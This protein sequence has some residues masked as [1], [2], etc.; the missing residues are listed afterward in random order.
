M[1]PCSPA[2]IFAF[3]VTYINA[4]PETY[5]KFASHFNR[6]S[7][8]PSFLAIKRFSTPPQ[9]SDLPG[10]GFGSDDVKGIKNCQTSRRIRVAEAQETPRYENPMAVQ[11]AA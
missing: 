10:F 11:L 4:A 6:L 5:I 9:M 7:K 8:V 2:E 3:G 1:A